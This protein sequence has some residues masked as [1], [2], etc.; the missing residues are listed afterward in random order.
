MS[1]RS[2]VKRKYSLPSGL[3]LKGKGKGIFQIVIFFML[4]GL[5]DFLSEEKREVAFLISALV[6]LSAWCNDLL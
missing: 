1:L 5:Y 4:V 6:Q 2:L 3:K